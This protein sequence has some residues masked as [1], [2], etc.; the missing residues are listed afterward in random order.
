MQPTIRLSQDAAIVLGLAGTAIS[1]A[2]SREDAAERWLRALRLYG[3]VGHAL[4]AL[5]VTEGPLETATAG[6]RRCGGAIDGSELAAGAIERRATEL[7]AQRGSPIV[8]TVDTLF[9][10]V[11]ADGNAFGQALERRGTTIAELL[12]TLARRRQQ[13]AT[14]PPHAIGPHAPTSPLAAP[15]YRTPPRAS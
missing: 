2:T 6:S 8:T 7:A 4:Q 12:A 10:V 1:F 13:V 5:G 15:A 3:Q 14:G 9:A 11:E